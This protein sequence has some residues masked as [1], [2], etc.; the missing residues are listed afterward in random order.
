MCVPY[1]FFIRSF[2]TT[3]LFEP[4]LIPT[5]LINAVVMNRLLLI[6]FLCHLLH[7]C[8]SVLSFQT[9]FS[10]VAM[11]QKQ[12]WIFPAKLQAL[13]KRMHSLRS[14]YTNKTLHV[15]PSFLNFIVEKYLKI[16]RT[17]YLEV[18][19]PF[20]GNLS[21]ANT[22]ERKFNLFSCKNNHGKPQFLLSVSLH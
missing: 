14:L 17:P 20:N 19:Q 18:S 5:L 3:K 6:F 7:T 12:V 4:C 9:I 15:L 22:A 13:F 8:T 21:E 16:R 1:E 11:S 2:C 10:S